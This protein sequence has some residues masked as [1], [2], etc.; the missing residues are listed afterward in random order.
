[1]SC[2]HIPSSQQSPSRWGW[3]LR[4][5]PRSSR[6]SRPTEARSDARR[7]HPRVERVAPRRGWPSPGARSRPRLRVRRSGPRASRPRACRAA[8]ASSSIRVRWNSGAV[9]AAVAGA[10]VAAAPAFVAAEAAMGA[11]A[12]WPFLAGASAEAARAASDQGIRGGRR[13][14]VGRPLLRLRPTAT[15]IT[16]GTTTPTTTLLFYYGAGYFDT[17]GLWGFGCG[18]GWGYPA[19]T[20]DTPVRI[21]RLRHG[22]T[23]GSKCSL[24]TPRCSS[25]AITPGRWTTSTAGCRA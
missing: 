3:P 2:V 11:E 22:P 10:A 15:A 5:D 25:T 16:R 8:N 19:P 12:A 6:R 20:A 9:P 4:Q 24:E 17:F 14:A 13:R 21:R 18:P 1:M 23:C 7:R